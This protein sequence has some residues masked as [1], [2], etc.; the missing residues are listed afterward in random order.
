VRLGTERGDR[1]GRR[2]VL[3]SGGEGRGWPDFG[4]GRPA[5][6][7]WGRPVS[8]HGRCSGGLPAT[9]SGGEGSARR[10]GAPGGA[11]SARR[12]T[13]AANRGRRR[14]GRLGLALCCVVQDGRGAGGGARARGRFGRTALKARSPKR[15]RHARRGRPAA[16]AWTP[17]RVRHGH[18]PR[19]GSG[20][21]WAKVGRGWAGAGRAF[22]LGPLGKD[23]FFRIYF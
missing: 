11:G 4:E 22:G 13:E 9:G 7:L 16:V 18:W 20:P 2:G 1:C 23:L 3:T 12:S 19:P 10:P 14:T 8:T 21:G 15:A 17:G 6:V 5:V